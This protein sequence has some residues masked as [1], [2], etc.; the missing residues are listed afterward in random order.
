MGL[1]EAVTRS[2]IERRVARLYRLAADPWP[3][4]ARL[5]RRLIRRAKDTAWGRMHEYAGA[6]TAADFQARTPL[7]RFADA[8]PWWERVE[9]GER[10]VIWP[11]HIQFFALSA[12]TTAGSKHV[13]FSADTIRSNRCSGADVVSL[14][15]KQM[16][17]YDVLRG[18][19]MYMSGS[20]QLRPTPAGQV[21]DASGIMK[22]HLPFFA[23]RYS[24]PAAG[25][26]ALPNWEDKVGEI[27][28]RYLGFP[29]HVIA[30]LPSWVV[31]LLECVRESAR[32]RLSRPDATVADIWPRFGAVVTFGMN[33][34]PYR[35][36]IDELIG[37]PVCYVDTYSSSEG[38]MNAIQDRQDQ[39][40]MLLLIDHGAFYEFVRQD[41]AE[42]PNPRRYT[43]ADVELGVP[44]EVVLSTDSGIW[45]YRLGDVVKFVTLRPHRIVMAGRT[46][47]LLSAFGEHLI[48][49]E[50]EAGVAAGCAASG[51]VA[52]DFTVQAVYAGGNGRRARHRWL[53]EFRRPP[54][55][56][57]VFIQALDR[58]LTEL[59]E[60]YASYR[61]GDMAIAPPE[62]TPL[63]P[64]SFYAWMKRSGRLG[65]Q[66]KTPRVLHE[67]QAA[68]DL[69]AVSNALA[70]GQPAAVAQQP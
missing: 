25:V 55:D 54:A 69:V 30:G 57:A 40:G 39:P 45:G 26:A 11:G 63:A 60:D 20:T 48:G 18:R 24:L 36:T 68:D 43:V 17:R 66:F 51:A 1:T 33:P 41:E 19:F 59:N 44:Y 56:P 27:C 53:V 8:R 16:G 3:V 15:Y 52:A 13:P 38:G 70:S 35:Q 31:P 9:A 61:K 50:L 58:R 4:Q 34:G 46:A 14:T 65:G 12:G 6:R 37:R 32:R 10:D 7:A 22:A 23:R 42:G 62:L 21:G 28:R 67:P 49:A 29:L 47:H 5:L 64:G 2:I